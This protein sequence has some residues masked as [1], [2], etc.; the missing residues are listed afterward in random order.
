MAKEREN[1]NCLKGIHQFVHV[2]GKYNFWECRICGF[3]T[4][5]S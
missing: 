2:P 1:K 3:I 5:A 4:I